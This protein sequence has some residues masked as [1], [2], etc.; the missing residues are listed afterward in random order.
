[1]KHGFRKEEM[2]AEF[3]FRKLRRTALLGEPGMC[4]VSQRNR[5]DLGEKHVRHFGT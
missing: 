2:Q 3:W 4:N 5:H 1:M